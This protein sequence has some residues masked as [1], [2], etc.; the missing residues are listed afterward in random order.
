MP[1][2]KYRTRLSR[3][4]AMLTAG[5]RA[6]FLREFDRYPPYAKW[7]EERVVETIYAI[8]SANRRFEKK[9]AMNK[10][11]DGRRRTLVG[12]RLPVETVEEYRRTAAA[13]GQSLYAWVSEALEHWH[14]MR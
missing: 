7:N 8:L 1:R 12:A 13:R 4:S 9:A 5:E 10:A 11:S 6:A 2:M 3:L 14:N